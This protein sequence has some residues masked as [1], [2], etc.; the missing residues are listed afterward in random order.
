[1][2]TLFFFQPFF[3][4]HQELSERDRVAAV[5]NEGESESRPPFWLIFKQVGRG[6]HLTTIYLPHFV[7]NRTNVYLMQYDTI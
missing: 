6:R 4:H 5:Q 1:M 2:C 3:R 7:S